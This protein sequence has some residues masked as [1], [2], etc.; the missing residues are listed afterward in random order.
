MRIHTFAESTAWKQNP[1][2]LGEEASHHLTRVL[3]VRPGQAVTL[4]DGTGRCAEAEVVEC[5]S[6]Q[7]W[8][9]INR[10]WQTPP[11]AA[12]ITL[13][14]ALPK[15]AKLDLILQKAVELGCSSIIPL[16]SAHCTVRLT[17]KESGSKLERW[18]KILLNAAEQCGAGY[19]TR[20][21]EPLDFNQLLKRLTDFDGALVGALDAPVIPLRE[22]LTGFKH[23]GLRKIALLIG[24]EGDFSP[25]EMNVLR[26]AGVTAVTFGPQIMRTETAALYALGILHY[27][28]LQPA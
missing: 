21:E 15:G 5:T 13:I 28:L 22:A 19:L 2:P 23:R 12:E 24:P 20:L 11:P 7:V 9:R 1:C 18:R 8:V 27:E 14:Q 10:T 26:E 25:Q 4:F 16:Q 17:H 6:R 3:R